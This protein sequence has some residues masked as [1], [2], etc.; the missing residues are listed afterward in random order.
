MMSGWPDWF[1]VR[2]AEPFHHSE[3]VY[4]V[5]QGAGFVFLTETNNALFV[6]DDHG[7]LAGP[8]LL[9]VKIIC[10][11]G[12]ALRMEVGQLRVRKSA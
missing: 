7:P 4:R 9:I 12:F 6:D 11:A 1:K 5:W 2:L 8:A 10:L 3:D